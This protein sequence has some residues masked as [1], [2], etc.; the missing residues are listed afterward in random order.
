MSINQR[1]KPN[2][3][4]ARDPRVNRDMISQSDAIKRKKQRLILRYKKGEDKKLAP[5]NQAQ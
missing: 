1:V 3:D 2:E 5:G 4:L